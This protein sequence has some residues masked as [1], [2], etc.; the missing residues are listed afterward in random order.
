MSQPVT[1]CA[2][3][4]SADF[5]TLTNRQALIQAVA[6]Y[7]HADYRQAAWQVSNTLIPYL[8]LWAVMVYFLSQGYPYW[9]TLLLTLPAAVFLVRIFIFFH[10]CSH[11]CFFPSRAANRIFGY[12]SGIMVFTPFDSWQ[13]SHTVHHATSGDLDQRGTGDIWTLTV[14]E[15]LAAPR[16]K[17]LG[18]RLY[19]SPLVLFAVIPA[20]L[21]LVIQRFSNPGASK[22]E[23][24]SVLLTNIALVVIVAVMAMTLGLQN[25]LLIQLPII[26]MAASAG[27]WLFYV[28]HQYEDAY[29]VR[30]ANWD[31]TKSGLVG[32]SYYKMPKALQWMVG[33]IGLHHIHHVR[34]NIPN[35]NLQRCLDEV[36]AL[37][38][39]APLTIRKS[40]KSLWLNVWDE[41]RQKLVGFHAL[42]GLPRGGEYRP[43]A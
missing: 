32:S 35:Y 12:I 39:V 13:H 5:A 21:F 33:N 18:Y 3:P 4:A 31:L 8:G 28:Q 38:A 22:R 9:I 34:A 16:L 43:T 11:G 15:Y 19:R 14:A 26:L 29:W 36:P 10:D 24:R 30:H 1:P 42:K 6:K 23:R 7:A 41:Q 37:Q 25:Y 20:A 2:M 40:F 27:M 17:R